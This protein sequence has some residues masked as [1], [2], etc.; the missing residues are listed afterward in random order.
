MI[1]FVEER[2]DLGFDY[3]VIGGPRFKTDVIELGDGTE[4]RNI[5]WWFPLGQWQLGDRTLLQ[6]NLEYLKSF[7]AARQG[8]KQGF[9]FKDWAD[10]SATNQEIGIGDGLKTQYQLIK[11]YS[12][13][14]ANVNKPII[15]PV[16]DS[17]KV[18]LDGVL[19]S[20]GWTLD[21]ANGVITFAQPLLNGQV[22]TC[23]FDFDIPVWFAQDSIGFRLQA[24]D[25]FESIYQLESLSVEE[26]RIPFGLAIAASASES[27]FERIEETLD[28][29][30]VY[31]TISSYEYNTSAIEIA[32]GYKVR[33]DNFCVAKRKVRLGDRTIARS[34]LEQILGLFHNAKGRGRNFY[35]NWNDEMFLGRFERDELNLRF[36]AHD[37]DSL[38]SLFYLSGLDFVGY[39]AH[40]ENFSFSGPDKDV[41]YNF[42]FTTINPEVPDNACIYLISGQW[43]SEG[44]IGSFSTGE[45]PQDKSTFIYNNH[46]SKN[47]SDVAGY[48]VKTKIGVGR[49]VNGTVIEDETIAY[50]EATC[51]VELLFLW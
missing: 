48:G 28:L 41:L 8:S 24:K 32:S 4:Q 26:G 22:L 33:H 34:E 47:T 37:P 10:Y 13:E 2:L 49:S 16:E 36:E 12:F 7:H 11:T 27:P 35:I 51:S 19:T 5:N 42:T 18:Y 21:S 23:D 29:N 43:D 44:S 3:G 39:K 31:S 45:T 30:I 9:R 15:K 25:D 20:T 38:D 50:P 1:D 40:F 6:S 17:L 14:S 46:L